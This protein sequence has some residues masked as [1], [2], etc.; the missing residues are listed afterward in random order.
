MDKIV[1]NADVAVK[2][3]PEGA[4]IL[5]G[6]FGL[7]GFPENLIAALK[8]ACTKHLT[9]IS[10]KAGTADFGIGYLLQT[11]QIRKTVASY[12]GDNKLFEQ[13][14]MTGEIELELNP[15]GTLAERIRAGGAGIPAFYTPT[16]YGT[17]IA[18]G[19]ETRE[20]GGR[21]YVL[22]KALRADF[23]FVK[24]WKG[25]RWGNLMF[26]K[27][28]RN[29]N[30]VMATA[31]DHVIAE[32]EELVELGGIPPDKV[33]TPGIYVDAIFQGSKYEKPIEK[34]TVRRVRV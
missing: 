33:H 6:G 28:A 12:V 26:R 32:V 7:C 27:T 14:V 30:P 31:A 23:A 19:K 20:F 4:S 3:I 18:E 11:R 15:Q 8:R 24:A 13:L 17:M 1:A 9:A 16:G 25:D 29:Y 21:M 2:R 22:E 34:R 10:N 5:M